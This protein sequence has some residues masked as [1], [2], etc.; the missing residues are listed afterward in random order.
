MLPFALIRHMLQF[1]TDVYLLGVVTYAVFRLIFNEQSAIVVFGNIILHWILLLGCG[2][3]IVMLI[4]RDRARIILTGIS[5]LVFLLLY[6]PL[7]MPRWNV[8][9]HA[10]PHQNV[11]RI[12]T[13]NTAVN[14][15][16][17]A[18]LIALIREYDPDI[19]S[20][21]ELSKLSQRDLAVRLGNVYPYQ[22]A[23]GEDSAGDKALL[24][25]YPITDHQIFN[26]LTERP[27]IHATLNLGGRTVSVFV[28]HP[29]SPD[30]QRSINFYLPDVN[31]RP[32]VEMLLS[33]AN[34]AE[35]TLLLG[36]FNLTDQSPVYGLI[37][38]SGYRDA[39]R[40]SGFGFGG[41][42]FLRAVP[43]SKHRYLWLWRD[44][45][46][47]RIDY[48]WHSNHFYAL[49]SWVGPETYSDHKPL[50]AELQLSAR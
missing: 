44:P 27:N 11:I 5:A 33:R 7:F 4:L 42:F 28:V 10:D 20:L 29:P 9:V 18:D 14:Y 25:K 38:S 12:M 8:P 22:I 45:P 26:L 23:T 17:S 13:Y 32:E 41:T 6:A 49:Q 37:R 3:L 36:D 39:F 35:P 15:T 50:F 19:V 31:H 16:R 40:Q 43:V 21:V 24:S 47:A 2:L 30:V 48:V 34:S 46:I 1:A